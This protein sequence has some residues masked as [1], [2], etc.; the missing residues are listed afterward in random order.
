M[1]SNCEIQLNEPISTPAELAIEKAISEIHRIETKYS[2]YLN[3]SVIGK[4]NLRAGTGVRTLVDEETHKL[5]E[6]A[7]NLH[8]LSDGFF[9]ITSGV[10]SQAWSHHKVAINED[11]SQKNLLN[12][13]NWPAV[14]ILNNQV[15]LP[16]KGMSIDFGGFGKEY[17][18]DRAADLLSSSGFMSGYVNLGGDVRVI[19]P[20]QNGEPWVIGIRDPNDSKKLVASIPIMTG[21]LA[22]S[23]DY[24]RFIEI[25]GIRYC[26]IINPK[27]GWPVNYWRSVS[28][29]SNNVTIAGC[30]ST[31][32]MMMQNPRPFLNKQ[33]VKFLL[34]DLNGNLIFE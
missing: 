27:T 18:A 5:F 20:R 1:G 9:D 33:G 3:D 2:R 17:A 14:E 32:S 12:L 21:G 19:G 8:H 7:D 16:R 29:L 11:D 15:Y 23:G 31:I 10:L 28:V 4:I 25:D 26:H 24:E 30:L 22:T 6:L 34:I 13:V